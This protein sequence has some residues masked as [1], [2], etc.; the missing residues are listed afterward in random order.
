[1]VDVPVPVLLPEGKTEIV[2]VPDAGNPDKST[3]PVFE[4]HVG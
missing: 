2:H 1:V 3:L 4:I